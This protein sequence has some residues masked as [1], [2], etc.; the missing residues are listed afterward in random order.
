MMVESVDAASPDIGRC[1]DQ[2]HDVRSAV[3][4]IPDHEERA[5]V[6]PRRRGDDP[7]DQ[8]LEPRT[9]IVERAVVTVVAEARR[10]PN[11]ARRLLSEGHVERVERADV[12]RTQTTGIRE[13]V[14]L[15]SRRGWVGR[16][17]A[18]VQP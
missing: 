7:T 6:T 11:G 9:D 8:I 13:W 3:A 10:D 12:P 5:V 4:F 2:R 14:C 1:D 15:E 17:S 16:A 18:R